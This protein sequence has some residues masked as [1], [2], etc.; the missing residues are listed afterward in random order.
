[1][2]AKRLTKIADCP[3]CNGKGCKRVLNGAALRSVRELKQ[4]SLRE[5]A[6]KLGFS[7]SYISDVELGKRQGTEN[8]AKA[9]DEL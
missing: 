1:M 8:I 7:A 4:I 5:M 3:H 9:Y 6:R 2:I